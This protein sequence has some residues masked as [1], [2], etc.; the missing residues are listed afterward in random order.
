MTKARLMLILIAAFAVTMAAGF[1]VGYTIPSSTRR[2]P[3]RFPDLKLT[4]EQTGKMDEIWNA[5]MRD[6]RKVQS[7][8]RQ[9]LQKQREEAV[10]AMLTEEQ[11]IKYEGVVKDYQAKMAE[12]GKTR[13]KTFQEAVEKTKLILNPEQRTK[14]EEWLKSWRDERRPSGPPAELKAS[15]PPGTPAKAEEYTAAGSGT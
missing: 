8:Q 4:A 2:A 11:K 5:V 7:E 13:E 15:Q 12:L 10:R 6:S 1:V 3:R 14:Y 9:A